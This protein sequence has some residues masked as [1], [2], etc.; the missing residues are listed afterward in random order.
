MGLSIAPA[1]G[2]SW[3]RLLEEDPDL[4]AALLEPEKA[5]E[6][7]VARLVELERGTRWAASVDPAGGADRLGYLVLEGAFLYRLSIASGETTD[8]LGPGDLL[9]P[10]PPE[11]EYSDLMSSARWEVVEFARLALLDRTFLERASRWPELTAALVERA[12]RHSRSMAMRL[13]IAQNR[14]LGSR[15]QMMLWHLADRFGKVDREGVLVPLRLS[16][17]VLAEL[18]SAKRPSVSRSLKELS[19]QRLVVRVPEGWRLC[20]PPPAALAAVLPTPVPGAR[21]R[22][23]TAA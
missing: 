23:K 9:R 12:V 18:V 3:V 1:S 13:T 21:E 10:W 4:G 15:I 14:H 17:E 16:H 19:N 2:T 8:L 22:V 20:G 5:R 7:C 11:D 6:R